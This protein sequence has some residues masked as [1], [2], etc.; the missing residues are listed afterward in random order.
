MGCSEGS[1]K[2]SVCYSGLC[3]SVV[4]AL[5]GALKGHG[6]NSQPGYR[7]RLQCLVPSQGMYRRQQ[8]DVSLSHC[9]FSLSLSLSPPSSLT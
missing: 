6:F 3:G 9:Y 8:T 1:D 5:S 4:G 2:E 7:P